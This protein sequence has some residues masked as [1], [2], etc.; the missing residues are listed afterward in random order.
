MRY[1]IA[2]WPQPHLP[3]GTHNEGM[4]VHHLDVQQI[5]IYQRANENLPWPTP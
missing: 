5:V 4:M 2:W 3:P 1:E